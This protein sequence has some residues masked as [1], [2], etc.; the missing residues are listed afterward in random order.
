MYFGVDKNIFECTGITV[1][2]KCIECISF[3]V[4]EREYFGKCV[5]MFEGQHF[6]FPVTQ[7]YIVHKLVEESR[8]KMKSE[9]IYRLVFTAAVIGG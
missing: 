6:I 8:S 3:P 1:I 4:T 5:W 7:F 9:Y 2:Q